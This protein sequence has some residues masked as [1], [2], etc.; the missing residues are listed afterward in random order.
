[1]T[2]N[3][4]KEWVGS[5]VKSDPH[6]VGTELSSVFLTDFEKKNDLRYRPRYRELGGRE[7]TNFSV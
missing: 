3:R 6:S 1:V 7:A 4:K 2:V 5:A